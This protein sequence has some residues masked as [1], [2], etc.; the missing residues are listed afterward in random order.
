MGVKYYY[1]AAEWQI[2]LWLWIAKNGLRENNANS[3]CNDNK[4]S[5]HFYFFGLQNQKRNW[6][7]QPV[8]TSANQTRRTSIARIDFSSITEKILSEMNVFAISRKSF[9]I[10][11]FDST[12][13][14]FAPSAQIFREP[15]KKVQTVC[16]PR[17]I[18]VA[19]IVRKLGKYSKLWW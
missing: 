3:A 9:S 17:D 4:R 1:S 8:A 5:I 2:C 7:T 16:N 12:R 10:V 13:F 14:A 15:D 6:Q 19:A 11:E 18:D